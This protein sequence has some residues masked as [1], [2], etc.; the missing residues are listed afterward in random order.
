MLLADLSWEQAQEYL[1]KDDR[2]IFPIGATEQ[3]GRHLGLGCDFQIAERCAV[4]AGERTNVA[5]APTLTYG[6]SLHHMKFAGTLSLRP[7]TLIAVLEDVLRTAYAHGFRRILIVNG[8]G[9]NTAAIDSALAVVANELAGL[10]VKLFEWWKEPEILKLADDY[11]GPQRGTHS[12]PIE[13]AFMMVARPNAVVMERAPKRDMPVERAHEFLSASLFAQLYPDGVMGLDP[14]AG[15]VELGNQLLE[16]SV[17]FCT[18][19]ISEW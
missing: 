8:H 14:S 15:T 18:R 10:R 11:A 9:G 16:K 17:E 1:A 3:H 4:I 12:S 6:M 7:V 2:L 13:T 19:E 5:V